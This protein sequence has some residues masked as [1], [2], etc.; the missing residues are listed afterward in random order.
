MVPQELQ[1]EQLIMRKYL[2]HFPSYVHH[3]VLANGLPDPLIM[4]MIVLIIRQEIPPDNKLSEQAKTATQSP[5]SKT[6][7]LFL[8]KDLFCLICIS[9]KFDESIFIVL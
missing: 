8:Q 9:W 1:D 5:N 6:S 7:Q 4:H 3:R 2:C